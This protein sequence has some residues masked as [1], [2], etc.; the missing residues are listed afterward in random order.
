MA[1][2]AV[3]ERERPG[4]MRGITDA[5]IGSPCPAAPFAA[6][7]LHLRHEW[8]LPRGEAQIQRR[9][10]HTKRVCLGKR[11]H[12]PI[13]SLPEEEGATG[14]SFID[15]HRAKSGVPIPPWS[16]ID[17]RVPASG[18]SR[19]PARQ[20]PL[21]GNM[22]ETEPDARARSWP[23]AI[24]RRSGQR[25]RR[26]DVSLARG[27]RIHTSASAINWLRSGCGFPSRTRMR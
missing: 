14:F 11:V 8:P 5:S 9:Q 19:Y 20:P 25:K 4:G 23:C 18:S 24:S 21:F 16:S 6:W 22:I 2:T 12:H 3:V 26:S 7:P 15:G 1:Q 10:G 17:F 27:S 13:V